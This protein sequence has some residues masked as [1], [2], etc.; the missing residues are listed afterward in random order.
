MGG[1]VC[2]A[3]PISTVYIYIKAIKVAKNVGEILD[4]SCVAP[5]VLTVC[6]SRYHL[7]CDFIC[8]WHSFRLLPALWVH[9]IAPC[10]TGP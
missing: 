2:Y 4:P 3:Y 10:S 1:R 9:C 8:I 6:G 5:C 7:I